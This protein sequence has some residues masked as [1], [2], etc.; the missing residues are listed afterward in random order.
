MY[1]YRGSFQ[2]PYFGNGNDAN[3]PR[4]SDRNIGFTNNDGGSYYSPR[5]PVANL[6]D[7]MENVKKERELCETL[8]LQRRRRME[9]EN[10]GLQDSYGRKEN[11]QN[12]TPE[13]L[14]RE[15]CRN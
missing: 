10:E 13:T 14:Y 6:A 3:G 7:R 12:Y 2:T 1:R 5:T 11:F 4:D 9:Q 8:L 15:N